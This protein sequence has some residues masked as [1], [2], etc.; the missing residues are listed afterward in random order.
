M[1]DKNRRN[2]WCTIDSLITCWLHSLY[3]YNVLKKVITQLTFKA[4]VNNGNTWKGCE[5]YSNLPIKTP[6]RRHWLWTYFTPF[7]RVSIVDFEQVN[8]SKV[9]PSRHLL[10]QSQ[11]WEHHNNVWNLFKVDNN[12]FIVNAGWEFFIHSCS[13]KLLQYFFHEFLL[14]LST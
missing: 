5:I 7:S 4:K 3:F 13:G 6:E 14:K 9:M 10:V 2:I 12:G 1:S 8:V 11:Q